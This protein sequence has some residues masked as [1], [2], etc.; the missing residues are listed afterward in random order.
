MARSRF[1]GLY[2]IN[3]NLDFTIYKLAYIYEFMQR[4]DWRVGASIG[5]YTADTKLELRNENT[6]EAEAG[7]LTAPLPVIGLRGTRWLGEQWSV[8][9]GGELFFASFDGVD[10][11]LYD[12]SV[13]VDYWFSDAVAL[14]LAWNAVELDVDARK[15]RLSADLVWSYSGVLMALKVGF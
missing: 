4:E 14:G 1:R 12:V 11:L 15:E 2:A 5:V 9:A 7:D 3:D 13:S 6:Q 8:S 10:G